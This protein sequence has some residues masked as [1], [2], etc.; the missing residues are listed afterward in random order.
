MLRPCL[1]CRRPANAT[2]CPTCDR[3][4]RNAYYGPDHRRVAALL[5]GQPCHWGYEGCT[6]IGTEADHVD[7]ADPRSRRVSSCQSCNLRRRRL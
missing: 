7:P 6:L 5:R 1:D 2:R 4:R 3:K